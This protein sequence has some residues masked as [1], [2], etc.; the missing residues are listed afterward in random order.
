M[1]NS[2]F[3]VHS[4][5]RKLAAGSSG[6]FEVTYRA[7]NGTALHGTVK[8]HSDKDYEVFI[9]EKEVI[10]HCIKDAD[11]V[12]SCHLNSRRSIPWVKGISREIAKKVAS[13]AMNS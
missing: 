10:I 3:P 8:K 6:I 11:G 2:A 5:E 1:T 7:K 9:K 12:I 4:K 13:E